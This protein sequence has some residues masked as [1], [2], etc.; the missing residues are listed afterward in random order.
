MHILW[1]SPQFVWPCKSCNTNFQIKYI[2]PT[3]LCGQS[4][5]LSLRLV[6]KTNSFSAIVLWKLIMKTLWS[7]RSSLKKHTAQFFSYVQ[8]AKCNLDRKRVYNYVRTVN[9][10]ASMYVLCFCKS[11]KH[12]C[13]NAFI[14]FFLQSNVNNFFVHYVKRFQYICFL[15]TTIQNM[16]KNLCP[17]RKHE[18]GPNIT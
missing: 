16:E 3:S 11:D 4:F 15:Y 1:I 18:K 5:D 9:Y 14:H 6:K 17:G 13:I 12:I 10:S 7:T 8:W 2:V